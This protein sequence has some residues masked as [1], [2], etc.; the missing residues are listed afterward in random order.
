MLLKRRRSSDGFSAQYCSLRT[1]T[2]S[3][4]GVHWLARSSG[5]EGSF[6][7]RNGPEPIVTPVPWLICEGS[8]LA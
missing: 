5:P 8:N 4:P 1:S 2:T 3:W 6:A 7:R